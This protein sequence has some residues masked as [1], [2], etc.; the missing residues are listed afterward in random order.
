M[1]SDGVYRIR[2]ALPTDI[3]PLASLHVKTFKET[4]GGWNPP[5]IELRTSQWR[6]SFDVTDG[7]WFCFV[8]EGPAGELIGF[9]KGTLHDGGVPGFVGELN[10]IYIFRKYQRM[11]LGRRIVGQVAR[12]F[13]AQGIS[14]MLLFGDAR[15]RANQFYEALGAEKLFSPEGEFHGGYGWQDLN[16]LVKICPDG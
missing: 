10:K 1:V 15:S 11:G 16:R 12:R 3:S 5:T 13:L 14:S 6:K 8:I 9:A 7:S 4:H 2:Q